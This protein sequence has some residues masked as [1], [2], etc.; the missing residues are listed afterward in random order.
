MDL[1]WRLGRT[2]AA[3]NGFRCKRDKTFFVEYEEMR[4]LPGQYSFGIGLRSDR[5]F[6]DYVSEAAIFE[7]TPSALSAQFNTQTFHGV[8]VPTARVVLLS[9]PQSDAI[10]LGAAGS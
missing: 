8:V 3:T 1:R 9:R 2:G 4:L 10:S 7:V 5:G 6:E